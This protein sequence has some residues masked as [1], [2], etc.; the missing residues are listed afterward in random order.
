LVTV[1]LI[2]GEIDRTF[3]RRKNIV[4]KIRGSDVSLPQVPPD[5]ASALAGWATLCRRAIGSFQLFASVTRLLVL[6]GV[7]LKVAL[8]PGFL[9]VGNPFLGNLH[10]DPPS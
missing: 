1:L 4:E 7:R 3:N 6:N 9:V 5:A 2:I 8:C 10:N